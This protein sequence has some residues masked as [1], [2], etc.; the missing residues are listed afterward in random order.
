VAIRAPLLGIVYDPKS[1]V[2]EIALEGLDHLVYRPRDVYVDSPPFGR[3]SLGLIDG[4]GALQIVKL[5]DPLMLPER[6]LVRS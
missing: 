3:A 6:S 4:D 2:I 1:D 5:C